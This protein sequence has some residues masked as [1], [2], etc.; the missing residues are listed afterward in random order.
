MRTVARLLE[1]GLAER[2]DRQAGRLAEQLTAGDPRESAEACG[3][4]PEFAGPLCHPWPGRR[5]P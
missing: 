2:T 3:G 4:S 1:R 5:S